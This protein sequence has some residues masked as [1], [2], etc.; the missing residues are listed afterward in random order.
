MVNFFFF[1]QKLNQKYATDPCSEDVHDC[2]AQ[3]DCIRTNTAKGFQCICQSGFVGDG[4]T[5]R[6]KPC[7]SLFVLFFSLYFCSHQFIW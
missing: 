3:A 1:L 6:G 2:H 7:V 5:C 4:R